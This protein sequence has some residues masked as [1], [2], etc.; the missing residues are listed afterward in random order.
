MSTRQRVGFVFLSLVLASAMGSYA[1][2]PAPAAAAGEARTFP[3]W[4]SIAEGHELP[5]PYTVRA[6]Y[7]WQN[8][9]YDINDLGVS[10]TFVP[11]LG[12][13][14]A[15]L[16]T[17]V[18]DVE[19]D[20]TQMG[21]E[22]DLWLL[23]FLQVYGLLGRVDGK[24]EVDMSKSP[25]AAGMGLGKIN[26]D[27]DGVVYGAGATLVYGYKFMFAALNGIYTTTDLEQESS[28][29]AFI[30]RPIIGAKRDRL[31]A[32]VGAMYQDAQEEHKGDLVLPMAQGPVPVSYD[33]DLEEK[34]PWNFLV[35]AEYEITQN[36]FVMA[37]VGLGERTQV[38]AAVGYKF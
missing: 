16:D 20:V 24:T 30:L 21:A 2:D 36:W 26:M 35:G 1:A 23:P 8:H 31:S 27:Y 17:S 7:Y 22:F 6:L 12:A 4:P 25:V 5:P 13:L 34:E 18:F 14:A 11:S 15:G 19:N 38:E 3:L 9:G 28:V 37:E 33:L 10:S 29:K 32:W